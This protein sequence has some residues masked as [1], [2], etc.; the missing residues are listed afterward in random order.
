MSDTIDRTTRL[1]AE[2]ARLRERLE[3]ASGPQYWKSLNE[4]ARTPEFEAFVRREF[5]EGASEW[6]DP[7]GRRDFMRLMSASLAL[8]G[9]TACTKQ[10][11]EKIVPYVKQPEGLVPG[12]PLFFASAVLDRGYAR[13]VVVESHEGRPTKLEGNPEHPDSLGATNVHGQAEILN[14]YDP[15][16]SQ[17]ILNLGEIRTWGAFVAAMKAV[18][19]VQAPLQGAGIRILTET[20]TSPSLAQEIEDLLKALPQAKWHQFAPINADNARAGAMLAFGEPVET[21]YRFDKADV[22]L[23]LEADF[24]SSGPGS[25]RY[26]REFAG[27]R[28]VSGERAEMNRLYVAE[29]SPSLAGSVAD[30]R[31]PMP[32]SA[33]EA[34]ARAV[35]AGLGLAVE[36]GVGSGAQAQWAAAVARDL[37]AHPGASLVIA[38]ESQ[39]PAVHALAHAINEKLGGFGRTVVHTAPVAARSVGHVE[40]LAEL[41]TDLNDGKVSV[42]FILGANPVHTAPSDLAFA[43][44]LDRAALRVHS[45]LHEDET[46]ERCHWHVPAAHALESWG[47]ARAYDGT[48]TLQQPL[49]APLYGGR[50]PGEVLGTLTARPDRAAHDLVRDYW[51]ARV[52]GIAPPLLL[53]AGATAPAAAVPQ[54]GKAPAA[55]ATPDPALAAANA[56]FEALWR[57]A[58]HDGVI[59]D[60][61]LPEK[62]VSVRPGDWMKAPAVRAVSGVE[63]VFRPDPNVFDGRFVNN[64]WLQELPRPLSKITWENAVLMGPGTAARLGVRTEETARGSFTDLVEVTLGEARVSGPAFVLPGHP[65][66]CVTLHLGY[67]RRRAGRVGAGIGFDAYPLRRTDGL[68]FAPGATLARAGGRVKLACTQDHW[69]IEAE[70]DQAASKRHILRA[71]TAGRYNE[72]PKLLQELGHDPPRSLTLYKDEEHRYDGQAWGMAIDMN[73]CVGCNACVVACVAENNIPVVGKEQVSRGREM[74]WIRVDR[75]Y[76]GDPQRPESLE[77]HHQPV[78]C[79]HCENAPCEVVCPVAATVH[80][81]EGLN[82]MV[83]NRCVGTRYCSNNCPYKVRRFN[84]FLY[85]DW[86]TPSLKLMRN[87]EVSVRSRGVM[88]KCTYCV[89]RITRARIDARNED[90]PVKDGEI[91]TACQQACPAGAI[92]FGDVN[93]PTSRIAKQRSEPRHYGL[94]TELN[95]RPRTTYLGAVRNPNPEIANG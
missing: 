32:S 65:E 1:R 11:E 16:R 95:T 3:A 21:L 28:K 20:V 50:T 46:S 43:A 30:H 7:A 52:T 64:G 71:T 70:A 47:D 5:P 36:G 13:G 89:Q 54:A 4:L 86:T 41:V 39:P 51:R 27:R 31:F 2:A 93:D 23:S 49:I 58:L 77:T 80:N 19:E 91:Q 17:A 25:V 44:A 92:V 73:A 22:V 26:L 82:D 6:Q 10:P 57:R 72:N 15:D 42:L 62:A 76:S 29:S 90:R 18:V 69:T 9:L 35:A 38:G 75:Y 60:T 14:L 55:A 48:V 34:F 83:Y 74:H 37:M 79:M 67:G 88:E 63:V 68:W 40:S 85:Q 66:D 94:L 59:P 33:V 78:M 81:E 61:A 87:P 45:G 84:F 53:L 8:A 24:A 12:R 56:R